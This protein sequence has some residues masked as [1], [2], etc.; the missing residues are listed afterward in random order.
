MVEQFAFRQRGQHQG[1]P[2]RQYL[3]APRELA[4]TYKFGVLHDETIRDQLINKTA[5]VKVMYRL[6]EEK[7]DLTLA[8]ALLLAS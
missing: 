2:V 3:F 6:F 8:K 7:E 5:F 1:E 4:A